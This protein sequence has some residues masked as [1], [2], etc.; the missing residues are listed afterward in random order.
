MKSSKVTDFGIGT[1]ERTLAEYLEH[2]HNKNWAGMTKNS[3]LTWLKNEENPLKWIEDWHIH[4]HL[5]NYKVIKSQKNSEVFV[6]VVVK[7]EIEN[8]NKKL[9]A[10]IQFN[11][12]R[13]KAPYKP[14]IEGVWGVNPI[15]GLKVTARS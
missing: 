14:D 4:K 12:I 1:A 11:L 13:E 2:W 6:T 8:N 3:Q 5:K 15:S 10:N 7:C 9:L